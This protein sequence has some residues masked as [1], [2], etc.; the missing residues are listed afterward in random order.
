MGR[1]LNKLTAMAVS[2]AKEPGLYSDGGNL[3]LQITPKGVRSWLLRYM[4]DGEAQ[5]MGLGALHSV[6][7]AEARERA[8][9]CRRLI[10][11][12]INPRDAREDD[13][14]K[15]RVALARGKTFKQ[16][17][18]AYI[19][20]HEASWSNAKHRWQWENT[21]ERFVY[22][23]F[24]DLPVQDVDVTLVMK[25]IDPIWKTKTETA[26]RLRGRIESILDWAHVREYRS[27]ENPARWRG[28]LENLLPARSK[29]QKVEH[30]PAL[31][32]DEVSAFIAALSHQAGLAAYALQ[33][34]ILTATRTNEMLN[35]A[36]D[37]FD[38]KNK[39]W[40]IPA[41]RMK[42]K[43]EHR[44]PLSEPALKLLKQLQEAKISDY[45]FPGNRGKPLSNTAMLMLLRRMER[46]DITVHGFRSSF[47]DWCAE[48]TN[49]AREVS[50]A[51]LAH[52]IGDKVEAA[53]RRSDLFDKRR[54]LMNEWARYCMQPKTG[55]TKVLKIR[56]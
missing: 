1:Q 6:S 46:N 37:E 40:V 26:S 42:M 20:A 28:R 8:G 19:E 7:L 55:K 32:Y 51:A 5:I 50:E 13:K 3:Y 33:L 2:K 44:V 45:V 17:A 49:F 52:A 34:T 38:L 4:I 29:I 36:W 23:V 31:P 35:A 22:P 11:A 9:E 25:V 43:K 21:L 24:G 56:G 12:G 18:E 27:G 47:R 15:L 30:H 39:V 54:L 10:S 41:D 53:Y 16:C 48:Q 14:N